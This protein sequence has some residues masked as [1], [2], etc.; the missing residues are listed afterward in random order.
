MLLKTFIVDSDGVN[1]FE[2]FVDACIK[3]LRILK[4]LDISKIKNLVCA[5]EH[6][7]FVEYMKIMLDINNLDNEKIKEK[8][9]CKKFL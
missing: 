9:S 5:D 4:E 2:G 1:I 6:S 3:P 7:R 8:L